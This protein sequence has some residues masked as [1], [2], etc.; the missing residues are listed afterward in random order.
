MESGCWD[1]GD[2]DDLEQCSIEG[3][4]IVFIAVGIQ[5][6][7]VARRNKDGCLVQASAEQVQAHGSSSASI[8]TCIPLPHADFLRQADNK[9]RFPVGFELNKLAEK[10]PD[11]LDRGLAHTCATDWRQTAA[12]EEEVYCKQT[13][14]L[15]L[16]LVF[17]NKRGLGI[18]CSK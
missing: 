12:E 2:D 15:K 6:A 7:G 13:I 8:A 3:A 11:S 5:Q 10:L 16:L 17:L 14:A 1:E 9:A 4:A 18:C